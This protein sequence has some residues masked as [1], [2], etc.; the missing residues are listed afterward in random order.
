MA[1]IIGRVIKPATEFI[2]DLARK[3]PE[4]LGKGHL[5]IGEHV[6]NAANEFDKAE[7]DL[8]AA[9]RHAGA[10]P[11]DVALLLARRLRHG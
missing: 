5:R 6:D 8:T 11:D 7:D 10:R 1:D 3:V 4:A 9:A 2:E